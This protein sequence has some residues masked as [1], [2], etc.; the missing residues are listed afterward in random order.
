M[1]S[2]IILSKMSMWFKFFDFLKLVRGGDFDKSNAVLVLV[3]FVLGFTN[4]CGLV[5][6]IGIV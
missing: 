2:D 5:L 3:C 1:F 6:D 4:F